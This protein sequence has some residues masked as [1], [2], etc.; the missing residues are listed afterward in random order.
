MLLHA[1]A[2]MCVCVCVCVSRLLACSVAA[3]ASISAQTWSRSRNT[4]ETIA[5]TGTE[6]LCSSLAPPHPCILTRH[7]HADITAY[8]MRSISTDVGTRRQERKKKPDASLSAAPALAAQHSMYRASVLADRKA[9]SNV[10]AC[11]SK[12]RRTVERSSNE[13]SRKSRAA[14]AAAAAD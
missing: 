12:R 2:C 14:A 6:E 4:R 5:G 9:E 3:H 8:G 7:K 10:C 13:S 1:N 11:E